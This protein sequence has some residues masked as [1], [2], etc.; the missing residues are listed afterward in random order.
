MRIVRFGLMFES[1]RALA[2]VLGVNPIYRP[3]VR[4]GVANKN[5]PN[6]TNIHKTSQN[7]TERDIMQRFGL[8]SKS[9]AKKWLKAKVMEAKANDAC[10]N[11]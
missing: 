3:R 8:T 7:L 6:F 5:N 4:K 11:N 1:K 9:E 2:E 10:L